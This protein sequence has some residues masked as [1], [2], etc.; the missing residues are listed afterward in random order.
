MRFKVGLVGD[1]GVGKTCLLVRWVD[2]DW[3]QDEKSTLGCDYKLKEI[4]VQDQKVHLKV[5]D[6][7]GQER[8]RTVTASFYRGSHGILLVFDLSI[9]FEPSRLE[10]WLRES[11]NYTP[12]D[13]PIIL[14]GNKSDVS[15]RQVEPQVAKKWAESKGLEYLEASAKEGTNVAKAF[16]LL[17]E[18]IL[19]NKASHDKAR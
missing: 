5:F 2:N 12:D 17:V 13:T 6:T 8:F 1:A 3:L 4:Q 7:A 9:P 10:D 16:L 19:A 11:R 14:I 15:K 18:K